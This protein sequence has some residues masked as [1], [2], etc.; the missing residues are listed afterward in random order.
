MHCDRLMLTRS[1]LTRLFRRLR[2]LLLAGLT[3]LFC[4]VGSGAMARSPSSIGQAEAPAVAQI[5]AGREAYAAGQYAQAAQFW[6]Q[7]AQGYQAQEDAINRAMALSNLTL[8]WL[9]LGDYRQ[10]QTASDT[11]LNLLQ[12]AA[13]TP[14]RQRILAQALSAAAELQMAQG[15]APEAIETLEQ[16]T[17]LYRNLADTSGLIRSQ[18]NQA[19]ILRVRGFYR[20]SLDLLNQVNTTLQT[21]SDSVLKAVGLRQL[22]NALRLVGNLDQAQTALQQ[23]LAIAQSLAS[24]SDISAAFLS[25]GNAADA[26]GQSDQAIA[27]YQQAAELAAGPVSQLQAQ[28]NQVSLLIDT[29]R[30]EQARS[31][32]PQIQAQLN[33]LPPSRTNIYSRINLAQ[34]L[35]ASPQMGSTE[36]IAQLLAIALDQA[37]TLGDVQAEA[38]ALGYLGHLYEQSEQS[39][40]AI[41]LT[42][43]AL[44]RAQAVNADF[45]TYRWQWQLGRLLAAQDQTDAAIAVYQQAIDTLQ[46]LRSDLA[47]VNPEVRFSF[48]E[49]VE[50]IYRELVSLLLQ[51][52]DGTAAQQT[53]L[54]QARNVIESLQVAELVNFFRAD[55]VVTRSTQIDQVDTQ[56]A[57]IYPII[58]PDR[59][60][61]VLSLPNQPLSHYATAIPKAT[62]EATLDQ[63]QQALAYPAVSQ[64]DF[65]NRSRADRARYQ[66]SL[67]R[68][69]TDYMPLAQQV[70][71]W[72]IRPIEAQ[73]AASDTQTLVFVLDGALRNVPMSVLHDGHQHLVEQYAIALT[74]GLQLLEPQPLAERQIRTII[75]ALTEERQGF[76]AL[77]FVAAEVRAIQTEV[78]SEVLLNQNF[79]NTAL[80]KT[81]EALPFPVIHLATHGQFSSNLEDTFILTWNGRINANQLSELLKSSEISREQAIELLVLSACE[82]AV[83]DNRAA[84]GLAGVAV[85]SGAR[86]TLA[87]LWLVDDEGTSVFMSDFYE[88]LGTTALTKAEILRQA[89]LNLLHSET[90]R[91]PYFWSP[92]ILVGNWL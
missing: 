38:Y 18:L 34:S 20:R 21:Q 4:W 36:Q 15:K 33:Q 62:V 58:L 47:A 64:A 67:G 24:P 19:Q 9:Q 90:Y 23:S 29:D 74:P 27:Y 59:L 26:Q 32:L 82:T 92:F 39:S 89:Q 68:S 2:W 60:E 13:D 25:L 69:S 5:Q 85:Q 91:H 12:S 35:M 54:V 61:V 17:T 51:A 48:R 57:V 56:A 72:L 45:I 31:L 73:L 70:Y 81:V 44:A 10:A 37:R 71:D 63:L 49:G 84:L 8:A 79:D 28:V 7:A 22:G 66:L 75:G 86:S 83:G 40:E 41:D 65:A 42:Q 30:A 76:N 43:Q 1:R 78:P 46:R 87:T 80:E 77:P 16:A 88:K 3:A 53:N 6:Q 55:C 11:S 50:P 52:D 14:Y